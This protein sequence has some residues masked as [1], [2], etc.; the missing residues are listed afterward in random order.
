LPTRSQR[1]PKIFDIRKV[2]IPDDIRDMMEDS[3]KIAFTKDGKPG[4]VV[5]KGDGDKINKF[6]YLLMKLLLKGS[7]VIYK[8]PAMKGGV[9]LKKEWCSGLLNVTRGA[10]LLD[11]IAIKLGSVRD[12]KI[13][14]RSIGKN[15]AD[16]LN[17]KM[18]V[19]GESFTSYIYVPDKRVMNLLGRYIGFEYGS[20]LRTLEK[21]RLS[22]LE[23][24][25]MQAIYSGVPVDELPLLLN[26]EASEAQRIVNNLETKNLLGGGK[27]TPLGEVA[28]SRYVEDINV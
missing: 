12:I 26:I 28:V 18:M 15:K 11:G 9:L 17:V 1:D 21:I 23:K 10:I 5:I 16:I 25:I 19:S 8:H 22:S 6:S 7:R 13:E 4:I 20:M 3:I 24:Q 27:L 2:D 14:S